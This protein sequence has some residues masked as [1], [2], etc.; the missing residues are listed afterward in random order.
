MEA[1]GETYPKSP[2]LTNK[3][4]HQSRPQ[5]AKVGAGEGGFPHGFLVL[6]PGDELNE[7][8]KRQKNM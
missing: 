1:G 8:M 6:F 3:V 7:V 5:R 4:D 2:N